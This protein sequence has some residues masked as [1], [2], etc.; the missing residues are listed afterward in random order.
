VTGLSVA[1]PHS[2]ALHCGLSTTIPAAIESTP[3]DLSSFKNLTGLP[4][5][6]KINPHIQALPGFK[7]LA[8]LN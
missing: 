1:S 6:L 4:N 3:Q 7:T 5:L 8:G 2:A